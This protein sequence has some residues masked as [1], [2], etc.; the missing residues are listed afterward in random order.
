M[1]VHPL[2][3]D[4]DNRALAGTEVMKRKQERSRNSVCSIGGVEAI[5][6]VEER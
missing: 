3:W 1:F 2:K 4:V 6:V 5:R